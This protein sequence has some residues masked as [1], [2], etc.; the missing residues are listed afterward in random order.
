M[1]KGKKNYM[2]KKEMIN[3]KQMEQYNK[4]IDLIE[5]CIERMAN[6]SFQIKKWAM[7]V[8]LA[9]IALIP[10]KTSVN[11][12]TVIVCIGIGILAFWGLDSYYLMLERAFKD[13]YINVIKYMDDNLERKETML[14]LKTERSFCKFIES[15]FRPVE[16]GFYS[17]L[18]SICVIAFLVL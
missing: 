7:A 12:K 17:V 3:E 8:V 16:V 10:E 13:K 18:L 2:P 15:M 6:N 1:M 5:G 4:W 9:V 11:P 14:S